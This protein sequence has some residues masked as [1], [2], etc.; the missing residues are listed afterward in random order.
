MSKNFKPDRKLDCLK[1]Y[2]PEPVVR[3]KIEIDKMQVGEILEVV[4][5]DPAAEMD[6]KSLIKNIEQ[7]ILQFHVE[8]DIVRFIIRKVK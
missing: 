7:E 4:A 8:D 3:T 2:C 1:L 6:I 5:D